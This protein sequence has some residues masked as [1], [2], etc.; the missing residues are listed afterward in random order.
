MWRGWTVKKA[1]VL[2][3]LRTTSAA[4]PARLKG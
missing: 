1:S 3:F 2:S 4:P